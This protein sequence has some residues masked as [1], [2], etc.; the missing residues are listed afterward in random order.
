MHQRLR[1][2]TLRTADVRASPRAFRTLDQSSTGSGIR[3]SHRGTAFT[4]LRR[5]HPA[6]S[7]GPGYVLFLVDGN[8]DLE[9]LQSAPTSFRPEL[10]GCWQVDQCDISARPELSLSSG[11]AV[12]AY[13]TRPAPRSPSP[14]TFPTRTYGSVGVVPSAHQP[15]GGSR[16]TPGQSR[17]AIKIQDVTGGGAATRARRAGRRGARSCPCRE[18]RGG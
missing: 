11:R 8:R 18:P 12:R 10:T 14:R 4:A 1:G 13:G 9:D 17:P 2:R 5:F 16:V 7:W 6:P 3:R 15:T